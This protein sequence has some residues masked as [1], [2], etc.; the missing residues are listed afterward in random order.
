MVAH[1]RTPMGFSV[2][3]KKLI[4]SFPYRKNCTYYMNPPDLTVEGAS[5][6]SIPV[7]D[8]LSLWF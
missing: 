4:L 7:K 8:K 1:P 2:R 3:I 6:K 5:L